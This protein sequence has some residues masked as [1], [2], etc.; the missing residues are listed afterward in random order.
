MSGGPRPAGVNEH[1]TET[2]A[3]G[4]FDP[5]RL[6]SVGLALVAASVHVWWGTPRTVLYLAAGTMPDPR[7]P[8]FVLTGA[9]VMAGVVALYA[10]TDERRLYALGIAVMLA[11]SAGYVWWH[12][13]GHGGLLPGVD[14]YGHR[15]GLATLFSDAHLLRPLDLLS[16]VTQL[17]AAAGFALLYRRAG[18]DG[19]GA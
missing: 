1:A 19:D 4:A 6:V 17:G 16:M 7:P 9:L 11:W 18:D 2:A 5:L 14:G 3:G 15:V 13:G 10:G 12:L 8:L